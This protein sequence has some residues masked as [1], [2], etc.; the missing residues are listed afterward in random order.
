MSSTSPVHVGCVVGSLAAQSINRQ[1]TRRL[2]E[3]AP[4]SLLLR[5]IPI[6]DLPLYSYDLDG[7]I[8]PSARAFKQA[9]AASDAL[10]F[11]TPEYNRSL[12]GALKNA[13]DWGSRPWGDNSWAGQVAG[14][15]GTGLNSAGT[16]VAQAQLRSVLG[17]L[18]VTV[19]AAP[20]TC[21]PWRDGLL[22][23]ADTRDQ[24]TRFLAAFAS[25]I[26]TPATES[27]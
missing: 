15:I 23:E 27:R 25:G 18:G 1:L 7:D 20:E 6:V 19:V 5:E 17:Y 11:V 10:L 13:I 3:L 22:D 24:L 26:L 4:P 12:P 16:A 9:I 14:V 21:L 2:T 8:P